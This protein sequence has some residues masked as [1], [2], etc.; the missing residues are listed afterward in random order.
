MGG[1][2]R[3]LKN[4][5]ISKMI[6]EKIM[7]S[8]MKLVKLGHNLYGRGGKKEKVCMTQAGA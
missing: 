7:P 2:F 1:R 3:H 8:K 5:K 4:I 6:I